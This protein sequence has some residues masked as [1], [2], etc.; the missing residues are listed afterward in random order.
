[1]KTHTFTAPAYEARLTPLG[2]DKAHILAFQGDPNNATRV[3]RQTRD[4][5]IP[6]LEA[7]QI[8]RRVRAARTTNHHHDQP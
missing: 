5:V 4:E 7:V 3:W 1:M 8:V 6:Y 2:R